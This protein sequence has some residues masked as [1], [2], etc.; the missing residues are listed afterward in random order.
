MPAWVVLLG[1]LGLGQGRATVEWDIHKTLNL[2]EPPLDVAVS[3]S[4]RWIF[5]LTPSG[6]IHIYT[7]SGRLEETLA[8]GAGVDG[9]R[10]GPQEDLLLLTSRKDKTLRILELSFIRPVNTAGSPFKGP[11]DA[12]VVMAVFSDFE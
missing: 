5:V 9:I 10:V 12:P 8:V 7:P 1:L 3:L 2:S 11:A 6:R 4:G